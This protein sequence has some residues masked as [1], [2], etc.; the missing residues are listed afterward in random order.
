VR[1]AFWFVKLAVG[2][3]MLIYAAGPAFALATVGN[4]APALVV[5]ELNG[6]DF[7]LSALRGK[8]VVVSFWATWCPPCRKEMPAL[9]AFYR[10]YHSKG[11]EMIGLSAD[12]PHDRSD[13]IKAMQS[14]SYPAAML[15]DAKANG[16]GEPSAL[17][18]TYVIDARGIVRAKLTPEKK[19]V[20][21]QSLA[22]VVLP[23][24]PERTAT[25][26]SMQ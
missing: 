7:D 19:A 8:V 14:F 3:T 25:Q 9:N 2:A 12:R 22:A 13:V 4:P 11:L 17:P 18:T 6:Q 15:D 20:T 5:P 16:F 24:L 23:L 26:G 10:Q 21:E 1:S